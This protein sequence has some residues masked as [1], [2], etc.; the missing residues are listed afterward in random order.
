MVQMIQ[1]NSTVEGYFATTPGLIYVCWMRAFPLDDAQL[2]FTVPAT[3]GSIRDT[4]IHLIRSEQIYLSIITGQPPAQPLQRDQF[5]GLAVLREQTQQIG[6]GLAHE[7]VHRRATD[8]CRRRHSTPDGVE[9]VPARDSGDP[10]V[11]A[12]HRTPHR[13]ESDS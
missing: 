3:Y 6:A 4:L 9:I 11:T 8:L 7:A 12:Q 10:D 5:P 1:E 13:S 2:D